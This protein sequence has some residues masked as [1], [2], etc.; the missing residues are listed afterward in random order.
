MIQ[1]LSVDL[2]ESLPGATILAQY[3]F[4]DAIPE[5]L[6]ALFRNR[7]FPSQATDSTVSNRPGSGPRLY[8]G[9][10][11]SLAKCCASAI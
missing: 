10:L 1:S 9:C 11:H 6:V 7:P 8:F 2:T 3:R 5:I 4:G